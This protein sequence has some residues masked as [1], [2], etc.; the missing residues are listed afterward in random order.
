MLRSAHIGAA[1]AA[2]EVAEARRKGSQLLCAAETRAGAATEELEVVP[3]SNAAGFKGVVKHGRKYMVQIREN[4]KRRYLGSFPTAEEAFFCYA[5]HIGA[6]RAAAEVAEALRKVPQPL[7]AA[8]A[9]A[10]AAAEG[11]E[12]VPL[13]NS[14]TGLKVVLKD[15]GKYQAQATEEGKKRYLGIFN[16]PEEAALC[17][18]RHIG[19]A[20]AAAEAA[21]AA[22]ARG[23]GRQ[24]LGRQPLTA[25]EA[26]AT[27]A[28]EGLE[29]VPSSS[30][31][32]GFWG[33]A[34]NGER[35]VAKV[36]EDGKTRYL[37]I[38]DTP[39]EAALCCAR[40]GKNT[41]EAGQRGKK[42]QRV[43]REQHEQREQHGEQRERH[44]M[45]LGRQG[46][47]RLTGDLETVIIEDVVFRCCA[48]V[49]E[50]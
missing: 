4:G 13:S 38:F 5:Q 32:T 7:T 28:A 37:G 42:R 15:H 21:E 19:A 9:R 6:V 12:L 47:P 45:Y 14:A 49:R 44:Y 34:R 18:A 50:E 36:W 30:N 22:E 29:L 20:R 24:P 40:S 31:V 43:Q 2:A 10:A 3:S 23:A 25:A 39:E 17:Y 48:V 8:E 26:M 11:L 46:A 35:Y 16:T 41:A 27:A 33:V 1:R